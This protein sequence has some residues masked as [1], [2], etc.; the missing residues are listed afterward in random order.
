[1]VLCLE[2]S[3]LWSHSPSYMQKVLKVEPSFKSSTMVRTFKEQQLL[4]E[5][6]GKVVTISLQGHIFFGSAVKLLEDVKK[7]VIFSKDKLK[8]S[9]VLS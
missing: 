3:Y 1:M 5:S 4:N 8:Y 2:Q 6:Q 7:S 9:R